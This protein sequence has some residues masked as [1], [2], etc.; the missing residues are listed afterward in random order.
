MNTSFLSAISAAPVQEQLV[1]ARPAKAGKPVIEAEELAEETP[2]DESEPTCDTDKA[3]AFAEMLAAMISV[4]TPQVETH[5]ETVQPAA[6]ESVTSTATD[7]PRDGAGSPLFAAGFTTATPVGSSVSATATSSAVADAGLSV[8]KVGGETTAVDGTV[9]QGG[10]GVEI[11]EAA[12]AALASLDAGVVETAPEAASSTLNPEAPAG[13]V[14]DS[15]AP[16][17]AT[18]D[19]LP[20]V[21][22]RDTTSDS[23]V[24]QADHVDTAEPAVAVDRTLK[25]S[26]ADL[27][28]HQTDASTRDASKPVVAPKT[29]VTGEQPVAKANEPVVAETPKPEMQPVAPE[30][31]PQ[32]TTAVDEPYENPPEPRADLEESSSE[33]PLSTPKSSSSAARPVV[34]SAPKAIE[35]EATSSLPPVEATADVGVKKDVPRERSEAPVATAEKPAPVAVETVAAD[36]T[37]GTVSAASTATST[38]SVASSHTNG[39]AASTPAH[40]SQQVLQ[41]LQAYEAELPQNGS[42]SFE[43]LLDPPELGRLLVQMSRTSKGVDVRISAENESVRSILETTGAEMQQSLQLSGF[44]LGQF[45]G[46]NSGGTSGNGDEWISAPTLQSFA[47]GSVQSRSNT[48]QPGAS[49]VNVMV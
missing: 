10:A 33:K 2:V 46:S 19:D 18:G 8:D 36:S 14:D 15:S 32:N 38:S 24:A 49:A 4:A 16:V 44:D 48:T 47:G 12:V 6:V 34:S 41:A 37:V 1:P 20:I 43:M 30:V 27:Q 45:S 11:D 23:T 28:K 3:D 21:A 40:V 13:V 5:V 31:A 9:G 7:I 29:D 25:T 35:P 22:A 26:S 39:A 42:R 17:D